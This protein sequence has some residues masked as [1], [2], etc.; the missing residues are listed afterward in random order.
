MDL[1][2]ILGLTIAFGM[3]A[4]SVALSGGRLSSFINLPSLLCVLG[5]TL[6]AVL[7]CFPRRA[8]RRLPAVIR[9]GIRGD[10]PNPSE[11]IEQI[12]VLAHAAR[13]DGLLSLDPK[14]DEIENRFVRLG[15]QL[16]IDG[17]RPEALEDILR[18][19]M[20]AMALRHKEGRAMFEQMGRF[21]PAFG[22]IGTLLGLVIM[23][24]NVSDPSTIGSG[25][26]VALVTTVYG[27]VLANGSLL[28]MAE[29]LAQLS[30]R[31]LI[32]REIAL[33]GILA[34]QSGEHPRLIEQ[35]LR[36][37]LPPEGRAASQEPRS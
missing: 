31:E 5:G 17:T 14:L 34:I 25:M 37:F 9:K 18:A 2:T 22:L 1:T 23:L 32:V 3:M 27:A 12:V 6:G 8:I 24:G 36:T 15:M 16:A 33:R 21:A 28:P 19:D 35:K 7:I 30:K 29:K 26:A 4:A 10:E 20:E 13:R 11:L